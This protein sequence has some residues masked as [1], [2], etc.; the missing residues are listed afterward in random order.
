MSLQTAIIWEILGFQNFNTKRVGRL[1]KRPSL[2]GKHSQIERI[3]I[4]ETQATILLWL[5]HFLPTKPM[6]LVFALLLIPPKSA[7]HTAYL[8]TQA[9]C[10]F[11]TS[12]CKSRDSLGYCF[13]QDFLSRPRQ[14]SFLPPLYVLP[15]LVFQIGKSSSFGSSNMHR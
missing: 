1:H 8:I 10:N 11:E 2:F 6:N 5:D 7:Y 4:S 12:H 3:N 14:H 9:L 13:N 15:H